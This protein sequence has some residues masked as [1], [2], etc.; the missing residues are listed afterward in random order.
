L[1]G[2]TSKDDTIHTDIHING[3]KLV[4]LGICLGNKHDN[5]EL[6]RFTTN[7]NI[8]KSFFLGGGLLF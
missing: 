1:R 7:K 6:H 8:A 4:L 2:R 5:F 3:P